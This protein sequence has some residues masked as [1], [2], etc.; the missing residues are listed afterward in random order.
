VNIK[1]ICC[2]NNN[3]CNKCTRVCQLCNV[4]C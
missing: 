4:W 1:I 3:R 2:Y